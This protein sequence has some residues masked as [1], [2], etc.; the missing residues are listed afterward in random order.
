[1]AELE[2]E[3]AAQKELVEKLEAEMK[4]QKEQHAGELASHRQAVRPSVSGMSPLI[5]TRATEAATVSVPGLPAGPV[6]G[7]VVARQR[8]AVSRL[9]EELKAERKL[10]READG[11]IIKLRAAINGVELNDSEVDALLAQ[12][13]QAAPN[14]SERYVTITV[15]CERKCFF[16]VNWR[17]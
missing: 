10:R 1:M 4:K 9:E 15:I 12:K 5:D 16:L 3:L 8:A 11:E 7:E 13:L 14:K 6:S 2:K 17:V